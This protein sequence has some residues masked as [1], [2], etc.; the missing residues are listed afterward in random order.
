MRFTE[1]YD[2]SLSGEFNEIECILRKLFQKYHALKPELPHEIAVYAPLFNEAKC[3]LTD[4]LPQKL[5]FD[6]IEEN[7]FFAT[8]NDVEI[9]R[10]LRYLPCSWYSHDCLEIICTVQGKCMHYI[11]EQSME[12]QE[13][14][15]CIVAPNT[16]HAISVFSDDCLILNILIRT[17]TFETAFFG[18]LIDDNILSR[19][20]K[21]ALRQSK[22]Y[23]YLLFRTG[24]DRQLFN[25]VGYAYEETSHD[26]P[27]KKRMLNSI[28]IGFFIMLLRGHGDDVIVPA[29]SLSKQDQNAFTILK[30]IQD[31]YTDISL[32]EMANIFNY[33]ERQIQRIVMETTGMNF[34]ANIL[35]LKMDR[36]GQLLSNLDLSVQDIATELGYQSPRNFRQTFKKYYGQTPN[37]YRSKYSQ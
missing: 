11:D 3:A 17:S 21:Y 13:G 28:I 22:T 15:I 8:D 2:H 7:S 34:S 9:Y 36:A 19:F 32:H 18:A 5:L 10:H 31:H 35:K 16:A 25:F 12:L 26:Y 14:D 24:Q 33:S 27:L 6:R 29:R 20:F 37:D 1:Y 30:Y 23:P 4:S